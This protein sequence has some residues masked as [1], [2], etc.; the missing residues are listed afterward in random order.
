MTKK[1]SEIENFLEFDKDD[2][3]NYMLDNNIVY[4]HNDYGDSGALYTIDNVDILNFFVDK[5]NGRQ[6]NSRKR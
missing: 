2:F 5:L 1:L 4:I 6:G 3:V